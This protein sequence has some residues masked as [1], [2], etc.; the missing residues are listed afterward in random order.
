LH[1]LSAFAE[2][3]GMTMTERLSGLCDRYDPAAAFF[4]GSDGYLP[5]LISACA[6]L[7]DIRLRGNLTTKEARKFKQIAKSMGV[8]EFEPVRK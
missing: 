2:I 5:G 7:E 1:K 4:N 6:L 8:D 3:E